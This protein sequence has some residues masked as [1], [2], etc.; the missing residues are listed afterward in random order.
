M[1]VQR[2]AAAR[3]VHREVH[4]RDRAAVAHRAV[5]HEARR[6]A[7]LEPRR[8]DLR[9]PRRR[10]SRR[11][12]RAPARGRAARSRSPL[13]CGWFGSSKALIWSRS[14][15][16]GMLRIVNAGPTRLPP[17]RLGQ[18]RDAL[19][20][21]VAEAALEELRA[22]R[23]D[24]DVAQALAWCRTR[25]SVHGRAFVGHQLALRAGLLARAR[26]QRGISFCISAAAPRGEP[27][28]TSMPSWSCSLSLHVGHLQDL[29]RSRRSGAVDDRLRRALRRV[30]RL[31]RRPSRSP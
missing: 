27:P 5:G 25:V 29:R 4:L 22:Q 14:S 12:N 1:Q 21:H 17:R 6:A 15:R 11:G 24:A 8:E 13:R 19:D 23:R 9:R 31:P 10:A 26:A 20:V 18:A 2:R 3:A 30:H 16:A 28:T 7:H